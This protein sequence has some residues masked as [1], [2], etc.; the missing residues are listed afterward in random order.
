M[1]FICSG[2]T[3]FFPICIVG[4]RWCACFFS[5]LFWSLVSVMA[6]VSVGLLLLLW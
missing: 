4:F 1:V 2:V 6:L 3:P 5:V